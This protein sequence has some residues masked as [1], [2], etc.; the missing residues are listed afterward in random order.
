VASL[1]FYSFLAFFFISLSFS[2]SHC[3]RRL[4][5]RNVA[6][7][8]LQQKGELAMV[9]LKATA[10]GIAFYD[11]HWRLVDLLW[12]FSLFSIFQLAAGLR[13]EFLVVK[14]S[15]LVVTILD[16]HQHVRNTPPFYQRWLASYK[17]SF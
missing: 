5:A 2:Y 6:S 15:S 14:C 9:L 1:N 10:K 4:P 16:G 8:V 3:A 12:I 17:L 7:H 13:V 11:G